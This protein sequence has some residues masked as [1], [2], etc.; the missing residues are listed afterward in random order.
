MYGDNALLLAKTINNPINNRINTVG[1]N[2]YFLF[3]IKNSKVSFI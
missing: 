2:Q 1:I 3:D